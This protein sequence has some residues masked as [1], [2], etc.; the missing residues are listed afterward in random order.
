MVGVYNNNALSRTEKLMTVVVA[1]PFRSLGNKALCG[2]AT[3]M[4]RRVAPHHV[5]IKHST[6]VI[7]TIINYKLELYVKMISYATFFTFQGDVL[8]FCFNN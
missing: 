5:H 4:E 2:T 1:V 7:L 3:S 8:L 6:L